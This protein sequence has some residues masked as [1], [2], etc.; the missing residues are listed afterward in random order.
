M[1][2]LTLQLMA[3]SF[4]LLRIIY[5]ANILLDGVMVQV[6][7]SVMKEIKSAIK[8]MKS[9]SVVAGNPNSEEASKVGIEWSS[10]EISD[11]PR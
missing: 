4:V 9:Y 3:A 8:E 1:E 11:R 2:E 7:A 10:T 5:L 6:T